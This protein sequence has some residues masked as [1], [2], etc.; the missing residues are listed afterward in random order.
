MNCFELILRN[1][2]IE[3]IQL[4]SDY[5]SDLELDQTMNNRSLMRLQFPLSDVREAKVDAFLRF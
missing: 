2:I 5:D 4:A 1:N 3:L